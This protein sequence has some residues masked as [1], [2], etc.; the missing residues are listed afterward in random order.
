MLLARRSSSLRELTHS[1]IQA[2]DINNIIVNRYYD[3]RNLDTAPS[4][5]SLLLAFG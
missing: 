1:Y 5:S 4:I 3:G 2:Y